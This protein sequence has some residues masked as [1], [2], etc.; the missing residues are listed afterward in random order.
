MEA[1]DSVVCSFS[2]SF[3]RRVQ[4]DHASARILQRRNRLNIQNFAASVSPPFLSRISVSNM[5]QSK[6]SSVYC[7]VYV[8][9]VA[10]L[11]TVNDS[12]A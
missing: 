3:P 12:L 1:G 8:I 10:I 7:N 5:T 2:A 11:F 6:H 4:I 9:N